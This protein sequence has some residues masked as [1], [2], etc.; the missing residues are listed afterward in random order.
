MAAVWRE[1]ARVWGGTLSSASSSS[2]SLASSSVVVVGGWAERALLGATLDES[3]GLVGGGVRGRDKGET[4]GSGVQPAS[5]ASEAGAGRSE[6]ME[7]EGGG[8]REG[9][10][11]VFLDAPPDVCLQRHLA[12]GQVGRGGGGGGGRVG[13]TGKREEGLLGLLQC[14]DDSLFEAVLSRVCV[15][16]RG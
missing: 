7:G 8:G 13:V 2:S 11:T 6:G 4:R 10:L 12:E 5:E 1:K 9:M 3:P 15:P 14:V 16:W